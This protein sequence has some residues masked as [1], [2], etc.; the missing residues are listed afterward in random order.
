MSLWQT[1]RRI[2][3]RREAAQFLE[4]LRDAEPRVR[5]DLFIGAQR[6]G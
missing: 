4:V 1:T 2:D 6:Q 5:A 3:A